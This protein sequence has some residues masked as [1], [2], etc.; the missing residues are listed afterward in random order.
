MTAADTATGQVGAFRAAF[1]DETAFA[2]WY[3][4]V[5]PRVYSFLAS[6]CGGPGA[7]AEELTQQ[8]FVDAVRHRHS[9]DGRSDVITWLCAI[10]RHKLADHYRKQEREER[11][12]HRMT[13]RT[14]EVPQDSWQASDERD[15]IERAVSVLPAAQRA[16]L[17]FHHL[18]GLSLTEV[19]KLLHRS[20]SAVQ[21]LLAR[22]RQNFRAAYE[23]QA[24]A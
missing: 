12:Q 18:D 23:G 1:A 14:S 20:P 15:A 16:A 21:S 6:R 4:V 3:E 19:G 2:A 17:L 11:R 22:A 24:D 13:A 5:F 8:T 10:G 7:L 9:F